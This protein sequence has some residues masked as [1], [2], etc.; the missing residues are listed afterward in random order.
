[1]PKCDNCPADAVWAVRDPGANAQDFCDK[2]LPRFLRSRATAGHLTRIEA[3]A[4]VEEITET[5]AEPVTE[6]TPKKRTR[7]KAA[8]PS[9]G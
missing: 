5:V 4:Q 6:D 9:E 3:P 2:H 1:M 8:T 7:K